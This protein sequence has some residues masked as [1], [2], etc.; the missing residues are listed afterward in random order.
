MNRK[1][2]WLSAVIFTFASFLSA[3]AQDIDVPGNLT[4]R[5]STG[6]EVGNI[7]KEG[8]PFIHNSG[9]N[10]TFLGSNAGNLTMSG[11]Y[12]TASG[13]SAL[14]SNTSGIWNTANGTGALYSNDT[15]G[16]NTAT[17]ADALKSALAPEAV[18]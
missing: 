13:A 15:G 14:F 12:N 9:I 10:N 18:L 3:E 6:P 1:T 2:V 5:D 4:M 16:S 8:V 7:L 11:G 17:G